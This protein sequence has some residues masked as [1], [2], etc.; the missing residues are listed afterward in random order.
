[1]LAK[2]K[3]PPMSYLPKERFAINETPFRKTGIDYF[4]PIYVKASTTTRSNQEN[5]K[6]YGVLFTCFTTRAIHVEV[7]GDLST[8]SFIMLLRRFIS[9]RGNISIIFSDYSTNSL[10]AEKELRLALKNVD[11][12]LATSKL[13]P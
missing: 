5:N 8:D 1:M 6:R 7:V 2:P 10:G 11:F 9:R 12:D 13:S 4:G 3:N